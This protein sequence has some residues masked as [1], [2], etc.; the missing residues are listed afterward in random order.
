[1]YWDSSKLKTWAIIWESRC[2]ML[3]PKSARFNSLSTRYK[4]K[5]NAYDA[6]LLSL[7]RR[8]I[9]AKSV[10]L[11]IPGYFVQSIII[12]IGVCDQIEQIVGHFIWGSTNTKPKAALVKWDP[13][14]QTFSKG[15]IGLQRLILQNTAY[16]M[17]LAFLLVTKVDGL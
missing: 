16:L 13:Y 17:K 7:A 5:F 10:L 6:R 9:L 11:T 12:P 3:G 4:K 15:R 1:M 14:Y 2:F 8:T